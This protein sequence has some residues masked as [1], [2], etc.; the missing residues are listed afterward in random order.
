MEETKFKTDLVNVGS[1]CLHNYI[2]QLRK[3]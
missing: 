3:R 2:T 1:C